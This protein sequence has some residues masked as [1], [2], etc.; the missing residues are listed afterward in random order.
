MEIQHRRVRAVFVQNGHGPLE[1]GPRRKCG[2]GHPAGALPCQGE[3][4]KP[5]GGKPR[6][7]VDVCEVLQASLAHRVEAVGLNDL[8]AGKEI[9]DNSQQSRL[10]LIT[11]SG[12]HP[13]EILAQLAQH[14]ILRRR[15]SRS[16]PA[17]FVAATCTFT[18]ATVSRPISDSVWGTS[19]WTTAA[20]YPTWCSKQWAWTRPSPPA[21]S[22]FGPARTTHP[23]APRRVRTTRP[24]SRSESP[25]GP[26]RRRRSL[27][28]ERI[29]QRRRQQGDPG[30]KPV[31]RHRK[32]HS[33][34][35]VDVGELGCW[36]GQAL[37]RS[38]TSVQTR[39][40]TRIRPARLR[41]SQWSSGGAAVR[42]RRNR[43][44]PCAAHNGCPT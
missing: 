40:R 37:T 11:D 31:R 15:W 3:Q 38:H 23:D 35:I 9:S 8:F 42:G 2:G 41:C 34:E 14:R 44:W 32:V 39:G 29:A 19:R 5:L 20:L 16:R 7:R 33:P 6:H 18:T 21:S 24:L 12:I 30:P 36:R 25:H 4:L 10:E 27:R 22:L 1:I 26:I 17:A 13:L 28:P 43:P